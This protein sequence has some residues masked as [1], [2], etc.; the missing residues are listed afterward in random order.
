MIAAKQTIP[1]N[2]VH[3]FPVLDKLLIELLKSLTPEEWDAPTI[4]KR[5]TVKDIVSHLLDGNLRTISILRD[6]H[7]GEPSKNIHSYK[8]LVDFLNQLNMSWTAAAKRLSPQ[9]LVELLETTG[10]QYCEQLALLQPFDTAVFAVSWAG[11]EQS[12]NWFHTARE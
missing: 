7:F 3:L 12:E 10:K 11:Q 2:T 6:H 5:W 1:I 8:E 9:I 4:A